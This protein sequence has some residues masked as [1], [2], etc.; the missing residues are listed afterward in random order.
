MFEAWRMEGCGFLQSW[1]A[2]ISLLFLFGFLIVFYFFRKRSLAIAENADGAGADGS[3]Q[4]AF[5]LHWICFFTVLWL[6]GL[7][8]FVLAPLSAPDEVV[9]YVSA[10]ELSSRFLGRPFPLRD[11]KGHLRIRT[12][13]I[14]IDDWPEDGDP[15]NATVTG[16]HLIRKTYEE[17][18]RR[19][20]SGTG[21]EWYAFTLQ[22]P[23]HTT[24]AAFFLPSLGFCAARLFGLG[25]FGLLFLGRLM[26]LLFFAF[27]CML[28]VRRTPVG[29]EIFFAVS[30]FPM[31]LELG[32]SLSY[33]VW[34]LGLS[35]Y[36][37]ALVLDMALFGRSVS[38]RDIAELSLL[39]VLLSPCK[40]LYSLLFSFC[41]IIPYRKWRNLRHYLLSA[42]LIAALVILSIVLVNF[43]EFFRYV[44]V[45]GQTV[46]EASWAGSGQAAETYDLIGTLRTPIIALKILRNTFMIKGGEYLLTMVGH[47]LGHY[48]T[49]LCVSLPM[50]FFFY[51]CPF[52]LF[53]TGGREE[54]G[55]HWAQRIWL[56]LCVLGL[57]CAVLLSFLSAYTPKGTDYALGVQGRYFLPALPMLLCALRPGRIGAG[58]VRTSDFSGYIL[59]LEILADG[60]V[61]LSLFLVIC[62]RV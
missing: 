60:Y 31:V 4:K 2:V 59:L 35:F 33:D 5:P 61:L 56:V 45:S 53:L 36:L 3:G 52:L 62:G 8:S 7:Y 18:H 17:L 50:V 38:I 43:R 22:E 49:G 47:P 28:S 14:F 10:Y 29:K 58:P 15:D 11:E 46:N 16:M 48:D 26:N 37:S 12:Q 57:V 40:M 19:G 9:H 44:D 6:G 23:I 54:R 21:E 30:L 27:M 41:L 24:P 39:A 1:F 51:A 20:L 34:I 13:D 55:L 25:G 42:F 32:A